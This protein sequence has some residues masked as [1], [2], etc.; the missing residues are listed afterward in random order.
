MRRWES[1]PAMRTCGYASC[2]IN[3][4]DPVQV[5]ELAGLK[6]KYRCQ[7]HAVGPVN[8]DEVQASKSSHVSPS[9]VERAFTRV[10][11]IRTPF[12]AKAAQ[13]GER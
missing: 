3:E 6:P 9:P 2:R 12:D 1:S 4:G 8:W 11:Q 13:A 10:S 7:A 5:I